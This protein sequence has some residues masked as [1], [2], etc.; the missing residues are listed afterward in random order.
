MNGRV[1]LPI[2]NAYFDWIGAQELPDSIAGRASAVPSGSVALPLPP[3]GG[4]TSHDRACR[5]RPGWSKRRTWDS[6]RS[7]RL[8]TEEIDQQPA[9]IRGGRHDVLVSAD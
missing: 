8:V 1:S 5:L 2:V 9:G 4:S 7:S 6:A 3:K